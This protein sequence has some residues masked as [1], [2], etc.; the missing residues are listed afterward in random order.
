MAQITLLWLMISVFNIDTVLI[1]HYSITK[2][3]ITQCIQFKRKVYIIIFEN[4]FNFYK[5]LIKVV[6]C[7]FFYK[8]FS[9]LK[10][11]NMLGACRTYWFSLNIWFVI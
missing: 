2:I 10:C 9:E 5:S 6:S 1:S 7:L 3:I 4:V 8:S 11:K